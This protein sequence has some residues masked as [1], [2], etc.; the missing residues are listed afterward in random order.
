MDMRKFHGYGTASAVSQG[1]QRQRYETMRD[2]IIQ[3]HIAAGFGVVELPT[4][5]WMLAS[6]TSDR[7]LEAF[8]RTRFRRI[9]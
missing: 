8:A 4:P 7:G 2:R 5:D 6:F 1:R 3:E 9:P